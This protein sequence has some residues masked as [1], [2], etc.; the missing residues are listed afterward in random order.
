[1]IKTRQKK[2][3]Q[4]V[5]HWIFGKV[6]FL[7]E[8]VTEAGNHKIFGKVVMVKGVVMTKTR[9]A[10][11]MATMFGDHWIFDKV[12]MVQAGNV[13]PSVGI[14]KT[15]RKKATE[16]RIHRIFGNVV[17]VKAGV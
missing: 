9:Q 4:A 7:K 17:I 6:D 11:M 3:N 5:N 10:N 8:K 1:M 12:V 15:R 16:V 14:I 2:E 13:I